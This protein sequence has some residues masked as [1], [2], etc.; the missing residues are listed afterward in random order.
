MPTPLFD[1]D[2]AVKLHNST[3]AD[4]QNA[5]AFSLL[6]V[7]YSVNDF[8]Y[9]FLNCAAGNG[10]GNI[11][12]FLVEGTS[13]IVHVPQGFTLLKS[14]SAG[15]NVLNP[16]FK[17]RESNVNIDHPTQA[18][19]VFHGRG[20]Q[21]HGAARCN[22]TISGMQTFPYLSFNLFKVGKPLTFNYTL[23]L[24]LLRSTDNQIRINKLHAQGFGK[25]YPNGAFA[26]AGHTY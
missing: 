26:A 24:G 10:Y 15:C 20:I 23:E 22:N 17:L 13:E 11:R 18:L 1:F 2:E 4:A 6:S 5:S 19:Q 14:Y 9:G 12:V 16:L 21:H 7:I 8:T 25:N 3:K